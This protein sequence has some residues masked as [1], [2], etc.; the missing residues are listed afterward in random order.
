MIGLSHYPT[1]SEWNSP[2]S[3]AT[4]S[5][6]NAAQ[7]V[8]DAIQQF[9]LPVMICETGFDVSRPTLA[10]Q[11]MQDLF[12][13]L[14]VIP[15]CAGIFYWEPE[16]DGYWKP[17]YYTTVGWNAYGIGAF[18]TTGK[19]TIALEPF[20]AQAEA[21]ELVEQVDMSSS[22]LTSPA[23]TILGQPAPNGYKGIVIQNGEKMIQR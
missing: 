3:G 15:R 11:V 21:T 16:T 4:H 7:Y 17:A 9:G 12:D 20:G 10:K 23:Y 22:L 2:A 18:T 8:Q 6:I 14:T 1:A 19:P 13:R 5:N